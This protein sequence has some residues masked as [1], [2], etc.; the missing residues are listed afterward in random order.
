MEKKKC[1]N[2]GCKEEYTEETNKEGS[3][4]YHNGKPIFHEGL[5][6]WSCCSRRVVN[7][8]DLFTI[9]GCQNGFHKTEDKT[10]PNY[11]IKPSNEG[12]SK[13]SESKEG[14]ELYKTQGDSIITKAST[15][16]KPSYKIPAFVPKKVEEASEE[17]DPVDAPIEQGTSCLHYCCKATYKGE[18]SRTENCVYHKGEPIF[19]EGSKYWS[20][21]KK[22]KCAEFEEML[23]IPG[24]TT[25]K[26]KFFKPKSKTCNCRHDWYQSQTYVSI[27]IFAKK[28]AKEK[29]KIDILPDKVNVSIFLEDNGVFEKTFVLYHPI[30]GNES[31]VDFLS[32]KVEIKLV[33]SE[34]IHWH[35]LEK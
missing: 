33:K 29:S 6:G 19:H 13:E 7:F 31:K 26:H 20:C 3:C 8:D 5:K 17:E 1:T 11:F 21:C 30:K 16:S 10:L 23:R 32:T 12:M 18:S 24:C 22:P 2:M 15:S 9:T 25:G 28:V 4:S 14:V 34:P 27:S 35:Y